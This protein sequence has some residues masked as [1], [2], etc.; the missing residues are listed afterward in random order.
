MGEPVVHEGVGWFLDDLC[1]VFG[2]GGVFF[3]LGVF[4]SELLTGLG[5]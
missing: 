3:G 4:G 1:M 2:G 5:Y